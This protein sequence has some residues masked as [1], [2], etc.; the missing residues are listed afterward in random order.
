MHITQPRKVFERH[1]VQSRRAFSPD[2]PICR[3]PESV[4]GTFGWQN[5]GEA[6]GLSLIGETA[7]P[8]DVANAVIFFLENDNITG[9]VVDVN[10]GR[11]IG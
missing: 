8:E 3:S 2:I 6:K 4:N 9:E 7:K 5:E 1:N 11:L 10:G